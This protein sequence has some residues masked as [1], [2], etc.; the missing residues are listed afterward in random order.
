M[1]VEI[2]SEAVTPEYSAEWSENLA[3]EHAKLLA[4][5]AGLSL[6]DDGHTELYRHLKERY[7]ECSEHLGFLHHFAAK[8]LQELLGRNMGI[9]L[10]A[11]MSEQEIIQRLEEIIACILSAICWTHASATE[12]WEHNSEWSERFSSEKSSIFEVSRVENKDE[13]NDR[14]G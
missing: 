10:S 7:T 3:W 6:G 8:V 14:N 12:G 4:L 5:N 13:N 1:R 2:F 11:N 9:L